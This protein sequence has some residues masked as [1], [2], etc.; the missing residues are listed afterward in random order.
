MSLV[1]GTS[2]TGRLGHGVPGGG[3]R[4]IHFLLASLSS[5]AYE[6]L[7]RSRSFQNIEAY[8]LN[9]QSVSIE[10]HMSENYLL[11]IMS[12]ALGLSSS[13]SLSSEQ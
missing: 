5:P 10:L 12:R 1:A 13:L 11:K 8:T 2:K 4:S 9:S 3:K 6:L 7:P